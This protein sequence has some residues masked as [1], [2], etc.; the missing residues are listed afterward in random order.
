[1]KFHEKLDLLMNMTQISNNEVAHA[2]QVDPSLIS[3]FRTGRRVPSLK[4]GNIE[5][6]AEY[7]ASMITQEYQKA[8]L[9]ELFDTMITP[10]DDPAE[11]FTP[12]LLDFLLDKNQLDN[13]SITLFLKAIGSWKEKR[14]R[15]YRSALNR[16]D[17]VQG[18]HTCTGPEGL[19]DGV[20]RILQMAIES[21]SQEKHLFLFS[22]EPIAWASDSLG[23]NGHIITLLRAAIEK[24][25]RI[26]VIHNLNRSSREIN[27]AIQKWFPS[28]LSGAIESYVLPP[29]GMRLFDHTILLFNDEC[30]LSATSP[31]T[32]PIADRCYTLSKE[33]RAVHSARHQVTHL[34]ETAIPLLHSTRLSSPA[35]YYQKV[36]KLIGKGGAR[37]IT[38]ESLFSL[39]LPSSLLR[40]I[41]ERYHYPQGEID[42]ACALQN[43]LEKLIQT[44]LSENPME[45]IITFPRVTDVVKAAVPLE[46]FSIGRAGKLTYLPSEFHTHITYIRDLMQTYPL[47]EIALAGKKRVAQGVQILSASR[48]MTIVV[49]ESDPSIMLVSTYPEFCQ[50]I[51]D[52]L[53]STSSLLAKNR[54]VRTQVLGKIDEYAEKIM[55]KMTGRVLP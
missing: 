39:L 53:A 36:E 55:K 47:L 2:L 48:D 6:L 23:Q 21:E 15:D 45:M 40:N 14:P 13:G 54:R 16:F 51:H 43:K 31:H 17:H 33:T 3:R 42:E 34:L 52:Y 50:A 41:L 46:V 12:L 9:A 44:Y 1:M 26:T 11:F 25:C 37:I 28:Y 20:I 19:R 27:E 4:S 10:E 18:C 7:F 22:E 24:G 38:T 8:A 5:K 30:V 29:K 32:Y 35:A 49:K